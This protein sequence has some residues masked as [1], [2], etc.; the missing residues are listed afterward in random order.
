[1]KKK[2]RIAVI[3]PNPIHGWIQS[4]SNSVTYLFI[5]RKLLAV[6]SFSRL[7][8]EWAAGYLY[9]MFFN[10]LRRLR[11]INLLSLMKF[12]TVAVSLG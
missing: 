4:M 8:V 3:G 12:L 1:M 5:F 11:F 7:V 6:V 9:I 10:A 2:Q